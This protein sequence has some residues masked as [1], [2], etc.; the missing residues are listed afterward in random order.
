MAQVTMKEML[1]AGVHFGHQTRRWNPKMRSYIFGRRNGI[2]IIDLQQTLERFRQ[3]ADYVEHM[4]R[5]GRRLLF[6]GTKRQAQQAIAEEA[7]RCGQF[8]VTHRWLGGTLTNFVTIRASVER[9]QETERKLADEDSLLTKK[10]ILRLERERDKMVRNLDGIRDMERLPDALFVVDP[11]REHIAIAEANKLNIPVVAIVDTNCDPELVDHVIPGNDDA[12]RTIR[13]FAGRIADSY[14]EGAAAWGKDGNG[15]DAIEPAETAADTEADAETGADATVE[16]AAEPE[17]EPEP[18][19]VSEPEAEPDAV[20][21]AGDAEAESEPAAE[22][23]AESEV[24]AEAAGEAEAEPEAET[25]EPAAEDE[26][27]GSDAEVN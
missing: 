4:A 19:A 23:E 24:V 5:M 25:G 15:A 14:I 13:L 18:E 26:K 17:P 21:A 16:A 27:A 8:Y 9:L 10:E 20:E 11:R 22:A 2:Y 3:A 6:V 1:E 12:I 7:R